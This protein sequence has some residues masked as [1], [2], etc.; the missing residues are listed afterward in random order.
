MIAIRRL[1]GRGRRL[2]VS[3]WAG[4]RLAIL[5]LAMSAAASDKSAGSVANPVPFSCGV[6]GLGDLAGLAHGLAVIRGFYGGDPKTAGILEYREASHKARAAYL[7]GDAAGMAHQIQLLEAVIAG[8]KMGTPGPQD[9]LRRL[10]LAYAWM[11]G[12]KAPLK[13]LKRLVLAGRPARKKPEIFYDFPNL[14]VFPLSRPGDFVEARLAILKKN[15]KRFGAAQEQLAQLSRALREEL[16]IAA[17]KEVPASPPNETPDAPIEPGYASMELGRIE[18]LRAQILE[19]ALA[20]GYGG[21]RQ[22]TLKLYEEASQLLAFDCVP[23]LHAIAA[24]GAIETQLSI[25]A[26]TSFPNGGQASMR[27]REL[28]GWLFR[29][30]RALDQIECHAMPML[31]RDSRQRLDR[32]LALPDRIEVAEEKG[33]ATPNIWVPELIGWLPECNP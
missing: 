9:R 13:K 25:F 32:I 4:L 23:K 19:M 17:A 24:L 8:G 6:A 21:D 3:V 10:L 31:Y 20:A 26:K 30:W 27:A 11:T 28:N 1:P 5:I 14:L 12:E 22:E 18:L 16:S 33:T 29:A 7:L 2:T 15:W